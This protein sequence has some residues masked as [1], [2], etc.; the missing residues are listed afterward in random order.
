MKDTVAIHIR[1]TQCQQAHMRP[2]KC[3]V[4]PPADQGHD[5]HALQVGLALCSQIRL[6]GLT[7]SAVNVPVLS[8]KM[9]SRCAATESFLLSVNCRP[10][11]R[12]RRMVKDFSTT[13]AAGRNGSRQSKMRTTNW[14]RRYLPLRWSRTIQGTCTTKMMRFITTATRRKRRRS[15]TSQQTYCHLKKQKQFCF[16]V[17]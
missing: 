13:N 17:L 10:C 8:N 14:T 3:T 11:Q 2:V 1:S 16:R 7:C 9:R 15:C 5:N 6:A 4:F 12:N